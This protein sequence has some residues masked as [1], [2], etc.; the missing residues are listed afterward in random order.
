[1]EGEFGGGPLERDGASP[2]TWCM[3]GLQ[4][5]L[6]LDFGRT[7]HGAFHKISSICG[8]RS[9]HAFLGCVKWPLSNKELFLNS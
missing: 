9:M 4:F 1:M 5:K 6:V 7:S 2:V 8:D 3:G